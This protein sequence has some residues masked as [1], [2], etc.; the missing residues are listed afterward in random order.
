MSGGG[1]AVEPAVPNLNRT[2]ASWLR[3]GRV[4]ELR[5]MGALTAMTKF[6]LRPCI[7]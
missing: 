3:R 4:P 6:D 2:I 5:R 7:R 1:I